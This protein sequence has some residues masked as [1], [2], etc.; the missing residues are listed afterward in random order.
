VTVGRSLPARIHAGETIRSI[1]GYE[2]DPAD[3]LGLYD[4]VADGTVKRTE[5]PSSR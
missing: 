1:H 4:V 5:D 2:L 3:V